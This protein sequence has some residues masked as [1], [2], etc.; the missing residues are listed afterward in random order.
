MNSLF[1][2]FSTRFPG[3]KFPF[4][5]NI[6][7][8]IDYLNIR[9]YHLKSIRNQMATVGQE[10]VLFNCSIRENICYGNEQYTFAQIENAA[11]LANIHDDIGKLPQVNFFIK[12][13]CHF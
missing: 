5:Y 9:A 1:P 11:K 10:P 13:V 8:E 4:S 6:F 7:Q 12:S 2:S 3:S